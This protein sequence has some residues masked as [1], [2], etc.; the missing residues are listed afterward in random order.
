MDAQYGFIGLGQMGTFIW[1][2][3]LAGCSELTPTIGY[4]M[5]KN[6]QKKLPTTD[7]LYIQD[8]NTEA[9]KRFADEVATAGGGAQVKIAA[10][11]AEAAD[12]SVS[13]PFSSFLF[14]PALRDEFVPIHD[15]KLA[16]PVLGVCSRDF[17]IIQQSQSSEL[18]KACFSAHIHVYSHEGIKLTI[19]N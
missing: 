12:G 4:N 5:A 8:I 3:R 17:I 7:V 19:G 2:S 6:L 18:L 11:P 15:T 13:R 16:S 14:T 9:T 1:S 10:S